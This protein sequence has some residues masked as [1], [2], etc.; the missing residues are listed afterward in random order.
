MS[1]DIEKLSLVLEQQLD[2]EVVMSAGDDFEE[3]VT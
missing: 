3:L 1:P 2:A